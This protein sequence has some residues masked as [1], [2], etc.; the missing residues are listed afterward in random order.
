MVQ[1]SVSSLNSL[2]NVLRHAQPLYAE[3]RSILNYLDDN[4]DVTITATALP[5]GN[6]TR[7]AGALVVKPAIRYRNA[8]NTIM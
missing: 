7:P 5:L 4:A 3:C 8:R 6:E 1:P 2:A